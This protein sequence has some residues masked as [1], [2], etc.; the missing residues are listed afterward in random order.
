M[1]MEAD[2]VNLHEVEDYSCDGVPHD[3]DQLPSVAEARATITRKPAKSSS[4]VWF[5]G[6][7]LLALT[8][9]IVAIAVPV[10][11]KEKGEKEVGNNVERAIHKVALNGKADFEDEK[12]YQSVA[13]RWLVEDQ[14]VE[15][16]TFD[17]LQQR[18]AM[19]CLHH[20]T[21]PDLWTQAHGWKRKGVPECEWYGVT[22]DP[23]TQMVLRINLRD[24][25]LQ[26]TIPPEVSLIPN[27]SVFNV[28]ANSQLTGQVPSQ[29]CDIKTEREL[30]IKVDCQYIACDCCSH[31]AQARKGD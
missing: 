28:N 23:D 10:S 19:Y 18:Y 14:L 7:G 16:Y 4:K 6:A 13:K 1:A 5:I 27:L 20:A 8:L 30:E 15:D 3:H 26:G 17:Q 9:F 24:N 21:Q 31:C 11:N 2:D 25:G 22:C 12:S 29:V